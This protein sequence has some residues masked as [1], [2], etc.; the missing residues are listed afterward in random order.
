MDGPT[1]TDLRV[2]PN[3]TAVQLRGIL[4]R[5]F[6]N[7]I[8]LF[9]QNTKTVSKPHRDIKQATVSGREYLSCPSPICR[10]APAN[11]YGN[12]EDFPLIAVTSL[13]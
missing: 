12:V 2:V 7:D 13:A 1:N 4:C 8:C 5:D 3:D 9:A 11:I 6:I 10:R